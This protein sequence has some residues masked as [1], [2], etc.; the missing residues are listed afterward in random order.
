MVDSQDFKILSLEEVEELKSERKSLQNRIA[1][2]RRKLA[3]ERKV[4]DA[5]QSLNRLYSTKGKKEGETSPTDGAAKS[6]RRT[7]RS[8][9][10]SRSS[11]DV[12]D[13]TDDEYLASS[14]TCD[15]LSQE[16]ST[17][18]QRLDIVQ[19]S[20]LEHT[21]GILQATHTGLKKGARREDLPR[22]PESMSSLNHRST[23]RLD[24]LDDFDD[25]SQYKGL[26]LFDES[27]GARRAESQLIG[28]AEQQLDAVNNRIRGMVL[29]ADPNQQMNPPPSKKSGQVGHKG[30]NS[31]QAHLDYLNQALE[32][33][34]AAQART[35]QEA[36]RSVFDSED[37]MEDINSRLHDMLQKTNISGQSPIDVGPDSRGK[38]LTSQLSFS[39]MVLERLDQRIEQLVE[40]KD[41][42]SR[43]VQQQRSLNSKSDTQRDAQIVKLTG[44]LTH[45]K[46]RIAAHDKESKSA[47]DQIHLLME[48]LDSARQENMLLDQKRQS[49]DRKLLQAEKD[50]KK[51]AEDGLKTERAA[52]KKVDETLKQTQGA[53]QSEKASRKRADDSL[54]QLQKTLQTEKEAKKRADESL[55]KLQGTLQAGNHAQKQINENIA[56]LQASLQTEREGKVL[57]DD[58]ISQLQR[59]LQHEQD[60][61]RSADD[62]L[63]QL[64]G[65]L[66]SERDNARKLEEQVSQMQDDLDEAKID[67]SEAEAGAEK[68]RKEA[69]ELE[70]N[71]IKVQ[72]DLTIVRAELDGAYGTRAQR[73][74]DV[75]MNPAI[76]KEMDELHE[77]NKKLQ[78]ELS[79]VKSKGTGDPELKSKYESL[80]KELRETIDDYEQMTK[81]SIDFEK[82]REQLE[83]SMDSLRE[84]CETLETQLADEKVRWLGMK[85]PGAS[86]PSNSAETT[87]TVVLKTEFKKMMRDTRQDH[88]KSLRVC[89]L[90]SF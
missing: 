72:T 52:K 54:K 74:A 85:S 24:G 36:Q 14:R 56:Q 62:T 83:A 31:V 70:E 20:I 67:K 80:Q 17:L 73:A 15:G 69:K 37:Q 38:S 19:K 87:S 35:V 61:Q 50:G 23:L 84:R 58:K 79:D 21:S 48:Q 34:E 32:S 26:E 41:I 25:R 29:Q 82:D 60:S 89:I 16:L 45:M 13:R 1:A 68:Y 78:T 12:L 2:T 39:T 55:S 42:L 7:R 6:P 90:I 88:L 10:G 66:Q 81:A 86:G 63:T 76:Q 18:E 5:A 44:E 64:Q 11:N 53:L 47:T 75:T 9:L 51:K 40:Q 59:S 77:N 49:D 57:A 27:G 4:R 65:S 71:F 8:L 22:S 3:L 46:K 33:I 30:G 28:Q 43:Q